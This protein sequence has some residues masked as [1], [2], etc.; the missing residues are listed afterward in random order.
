MPGVNALKSK[1]G[2]A[3]S[4]MDS[5]VETGPEIYPLE[6]NISYFGSMLGLLNTSVSLSALVLVLSDLGWTLFCLRGPQAKV[7]PSGL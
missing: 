7:E 2:H 4:V 6:H 5:Q 3:R 1:M